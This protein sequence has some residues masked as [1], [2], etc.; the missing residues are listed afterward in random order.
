[1]DY[2]MGPAKHFRDLLAWQ[3]AYKLTLRIYATANSFPQSEMYGLTSQIKRAIVSVTSNIAEG[4]GR[5]SS[6]EKD[7]FY[8]MAH[9]S[10]TEVENQLIIAKGVGYIDTAEL[11]EIMVIVNE[12]HRLLYGLR[13]AN[14]DK[15]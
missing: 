5:R 3:S 14:K 1:M 12:S 2:G 10:L 11:E 6:K 9:A 8:A 15:S 4:F 13:R 7:Q